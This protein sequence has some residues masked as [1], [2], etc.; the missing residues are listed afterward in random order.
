MPRRLDLELSEEVYLVL[1]VLSGRTVCS[2][3]DLVQHFLLRPSRHH[4]RPCLSLPRAMACS[5][6]L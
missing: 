3:R 5:L 1:E 6:R 2:I 4:C